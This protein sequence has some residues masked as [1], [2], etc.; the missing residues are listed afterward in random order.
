VKVEEQ[1]DEYGS[2]VASR[3]PPK[4]RNSQDG[5][6]VPSLGLTVVERP[7]GILIAKINADGV[8]ADELN[9]GAYITS[10]E[11]KEV[12]TLPEFKKLIEAA[13]VAGKGVLLTVRNA[14]GGT[15][16]LVLKGKK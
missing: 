8:A 15:R 13:D 9:E 1:P 10:I 3:R 11:G 12:K 6:E 2:A 5:I 14:D 4:N 7:Q 16:M